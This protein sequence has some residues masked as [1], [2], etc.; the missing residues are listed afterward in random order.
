[1]FFSLM[2]LDLCSGQ[3]ALLQSTLNKARQ[4][5]YHTGSVL[6][7]NGLTEAA[8]YPPT[9]PCLMAGGALLVCDVSRR[10]GAAWVGAGDRIG[11]HRGWKLN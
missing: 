2:H 3:S 9:I 10:L 5:E 6:L 1:M 4:S 8:S 7:A 11:R